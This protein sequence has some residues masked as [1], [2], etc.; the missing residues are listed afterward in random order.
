MERKTKGMRSVKMS[1]EKLIHW[2]K[3]DPDRY[4]GY[5]DGVCTYWLQVDDRR[6]VR[7]ALEENTNNYLVKCLTLDD[8]WR[9]VKKHELDRM[10]MRLG[11]VNRLGDV[12][13]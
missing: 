12:S 11:K 9:F 8:A 1:D 2:E 3:V 10:S 7:V 13:E 5:V 4:E 6:K